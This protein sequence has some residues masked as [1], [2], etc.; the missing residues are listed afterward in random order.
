PRQ[1]SMTHYADMIRLFG[2]PNGLCSLITE[3]KHI[4]AVKQ[5]WR[6]SSKHNTIGQMLLANQR[7][8]KL[9]ASRVDFTTRG[10]LVGS[11]LS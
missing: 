11:V 1:H 4:K 3:S 7:L 10:M 6:W 5:P 8:D 9:A 2:A